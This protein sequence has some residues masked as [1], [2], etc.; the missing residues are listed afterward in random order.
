[1]YGWFHAYLLGCSTGFVVNNGI[2][3]C[4]MFWWGLIDGVNKRKN[5]IYKRDYKLLG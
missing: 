1:M 3:H 4:P 2:K 5:S